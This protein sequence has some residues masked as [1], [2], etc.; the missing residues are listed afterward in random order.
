MNMRTSSSLRCWSFVIGAACAAT[1]LAA[2]PPAKDE[3]IALTINREANDY[4]VRCEVKLSGRILVATKGSTKENPQSLSLKADSLIDYQERLTREEGIPIA[5]QRKYL[6]AKSTGE[7]QGSKQEIILR[8]EASNVSV[9]CDA[10][11][12][13]YYSDEFLLSEKELELLRLPTQ[14]FAVDRV[15]PTS[16]VKIGETWS[17]PREAVAGLLD[18]SVIDKAEVTCRLASATE[19]AARLEM[20]GSVQGMVEGVATTIKLAAKLQFKQQLGVI[21]WMAMSI[22]E[23]RER[24]TA[25]PGFDVNAQVKLVREVIARENSQ[26]TKEA[27]SLDQPVPPEQLIF[28]V[29]GGAGFS[30]LAA[31]AWRVVAD[32]PKQTMLRMVHNNQIVASCEIRSLT[33]MKSGEQLTLEAFQADV[34][35][36]LRDQ[37][38]SFLESEEKAND[39]GTRVLRVVATGTVQGGPVNWHYLQ[40]SNDAGRRVS[41]VFT[42]DG[43]NA[44]QFNGADVQL[45]STFQFVTEQVAARD[46][47]RNSQ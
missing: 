12:A 15:L 4:R 6:E 34:K 5:A 33:P 24:G 43:K 2:N 44:E 18:L 27:V 14:S 41:A 45:G 23:Q 25:E 1:V 21:D 26:V 37:F 31:R 13:T 36:A 28:D 17:V 22:Q 29:Q 38:G 46:T 8:P 47:E 11:R 42:L 20:I 3:R 10:G 40:L 16:P 35:T 7:V 19:Q 30:T 32:S 39:L 9:R